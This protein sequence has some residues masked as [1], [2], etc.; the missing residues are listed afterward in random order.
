MPP[1]SGS[2]ARLPA[3]APLTARYLQAMLPDW[4]CLRSLVGLCLMGMHLS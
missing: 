2:L 1:Q 4:S 3:D